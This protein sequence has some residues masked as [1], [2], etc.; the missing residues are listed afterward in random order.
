MLASGALARNVSFIVAIEGFVGSFVG[1]LVDRPPPLRFRGSDLLYPLLF[2]SKAD[3]T[4][5]PGLVS[6]YTMAHRR[7][8]PIL[9]R[10]I[11]A[12]FAHRGR[13]PQMPGCAPA[14]DCDQGA[15]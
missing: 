13:R 2:G 14:G 8:P 3:I 7:W 15:M 10:G 1:S 12:D 4:A 5:A 9:C 11:G 6:R